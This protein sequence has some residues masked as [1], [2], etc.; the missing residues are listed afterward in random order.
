MKI[1][2]LQQVDSTHTYLKNYIKNL[3]KFEPTCI[4]T[5]YQTNGIGSRGNSWTGVKGNLF[6]SFVYKVDNLPKDLPIQSCSIFFSYILK[7]ILEESNSKVWIKWPND[8]Y[9]ND[10][11]IGGTI[12]TMSN[13]LLF[14]GIGI[15]LI[16][17][18]YEFGKLDIKIDIEKTLKNY[19]NKIENQTSWKQI[20]R[21]F[22]I[23]FQNSKKFHVS[24]G[25]EKK[26]LKD[27]VLNS[28][29]SINIDNKKVF[30]LR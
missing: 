16:D 20:F 6:F 14:C 25:N 4:L 30:S 23:E 12:T 11:K 28:D 17:V 10:K 9:I 27:A 3:E 26:S 19:F 1:I 29:G 5:N 2:K 22:K 21:D 7:K 24:I 18:S 13:D 15:N 8:F